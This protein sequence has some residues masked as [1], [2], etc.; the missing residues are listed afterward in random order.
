MPCVVVEPTA[1]RRRLERHLTSG[2]FGPFSKQQGTT[3]VTDV[4]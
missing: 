4:A 3:V 1:D 2:G